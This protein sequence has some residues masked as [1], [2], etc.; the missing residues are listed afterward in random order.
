MTTT[1]TRIFRRLF[2]ECSIWNT[3][4][5]D[6]AVEKSVVLTLRHEIAPPVGQDNKKVQ[7]PSFRVV[8]EPREVVKGPRQELEAVRAWGVEV[9]VHIANARGQDI[10]RYL[11]RRKI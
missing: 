1:E 3:D 6:V 11:S 8:Q 2:G 10:T 5:N 9:V 7:G 4:S